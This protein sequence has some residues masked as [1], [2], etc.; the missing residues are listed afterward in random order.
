MFRIRRNPKSHGSYRTSRMSCRIGRKLSICRI[1][2]KRNS[3][4]IGIILRNLRMLR[5]LRILRIHRIPCIVIKSHRK[6]CSVRSFNIY[7]MLIQ[8]L[9]ILNILKLP[10]VIRSLS[11]QAFT[12]CKV[13]AID[14][15]LQ[16][17]LT[18]QEAVEWANECTPYYFSNNIQTTHQPWTMTGQLQ[19]N[20]S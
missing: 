3:C 9:Q 10:R 8:Y 16:P 15:L 2:R 5:I 13:K 19:S 7:G 1:P 11:L 12:Y 17:W 20:S 18:D 6:Y 14:H 4:T